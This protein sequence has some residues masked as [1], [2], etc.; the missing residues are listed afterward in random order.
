MLF[1]VN[2]ILLSNAFIYPNGAFILKVLPLISFLIVIKFPEISTFSK[3]IKINLKSLN[4]SY[5]FL[6]YN[7]KK[8]IYPFRFRVFVALAFF[9]VF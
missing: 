1:S 4:I 5:F 8:G 9:I 6:I 3:A 2:K 7:N